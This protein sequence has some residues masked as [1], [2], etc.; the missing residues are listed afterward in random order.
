MFGIF[1]NYQKFLQYQ[2]ILP[3]FGGAPAVICA[4]VVAE[5]QALEGTIL[6]QNSTT[7]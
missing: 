4:G 6:K 1:A 3:R 5:P 2:R 7:I